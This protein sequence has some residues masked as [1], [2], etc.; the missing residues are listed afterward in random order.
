MPVGPVRRVGAQL[1]EKLGCA[2]SGCPVLS[3]LACSMVRGQK[4]VHFATNGLK[5]KH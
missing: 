2:L 4:L 5:R 3:S 1:A